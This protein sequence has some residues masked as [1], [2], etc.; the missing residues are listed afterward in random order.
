M[1]SPK[2]TNKIIKREKDL[3]LPIDL[4]LVT[5][6]GLPFSIR[7]INVLTRN[8]IF[9]LKDLF[10]KN[11]DFLI[12]I[13]IGKKGLSEIVNLKAKYIYQNLVEVHL[14]FAVI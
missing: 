5:I 7:T 9:T 2:Q 14:C 11:T 1:I 8:K 13:N 12:S 4:S 10:D 6:N 3:V